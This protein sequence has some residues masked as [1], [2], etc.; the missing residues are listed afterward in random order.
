MSESQPGRQADTRDAAG[1]RVQTQKQEFAELE[2]NRASGDG[3]RVGRASDNHPT[4]DLMKA[5]NTG[6]FAEASPGQP[7]E[8]VAQDIGGPSGSEL[9][10]SAPFQSRVYYKSVARLGYQVAEALHYAHTN[11]VI[12]R[13]IKPSNLLI[14][15]EG[16]VWIT[17]FG[18]AKPLE[19]DGLTR[20]GD[21]LGTLR[22]M[23]PEQIEGK[24]D[25]RS[26]LYS[27]GLTLYELATLE[28][29]FA[30]DSHAQLFRSKQEGKIVPPRRLSP[31]LPRDLETII[32]KS[33]AADPQLR[34][35]NAGELAR[36]LQRFLEDRP[37]E[38]RRTS[39]WEKM[40]SW[41]RRNPAIA[42]LTGVALLLL[43]STALVASIGY[44]QTRAALGLAQKNAEALAAKSN[45]A[46]R[47]LEDAI[48]AQELAE[49]NESL[50]LLAEYRSLGN[51]ELALDAFEVIAANLAN[52]GVPQT[53]EWELAG[54]APV[55]AGQVTDEDARLLQS[56]LGFYQQF[57]VDEASD[58]VVVAKTA[59]AWT[60]MGAIHT[61]LGQYEQ[62]EQAYLDALQL[63]NSLLKELEETLAADSAGDRQRSTWLELVQDKSKAQDGLIRVYG[64]SNE[65]DKLL[66]AYGM[67]RDFLT[68]AV[69]QSSR[70]TERDPLRFALGRSLDQFCSTLIRMGLAESEFEDAQPESAP[71]SPRTLVR[72]FIRKLATPDAGLGA[73][74]APGGENFDGSFRPLRLRAELITSPLEFIL[75]ELQAAENIFAS[76]LND[77]PDNEA[78]RHA[79]A[80]TARHLMVL[81]QN[82]GSRRKAG[83]HFDSSV[84]LLESLVDEFP[85]NPT[86]RFE[87][88]DVYS[89]AQA[90]FPSVGSADAAREKIL[91]SIADAGT[92]ISR[93]PA[94]LEYRL[95][96]AQGHRQLAVLENSL[97]SLQLA[98]Y[99]LR[100][101]MD[102]L[103]ELRQEH[104]DP[105]G[106]LVSL[107]LNQKLYCDA[108]R[109]TG[110]ARD[111]AKLI[112][113][114][115]DVLDVVLE[116]LVQEARSR[117]S[118]FLA[119]VASS[120][121]LSKAKSHLEIGQWERALQFE[122]LSQY[123]SMR[124]FGGGRFGNSQ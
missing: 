59:R 121:L 93:F 66:L 100:T 5:T 58:R 110:I 57:H 54:D 112:Y 95:L 40:L 79:L 41:S 72:Q 88:A 109:T 91:Q 43:M 7:V 90:Q 86:Y 39:A 14:D 37:I 117:K 36:E 83:R 53:L 47:N 56:L 55:W 42:T 68:S 17:D 98:E 21:T 76:L 1:S 45:E 84:Q 44:F 61:R 35:A 9:Q 78:Y 64:Q 105:L 107:A 122:R 111:D 60:H 16:V 3:G 123:F 23:S 2:I 94:E 51:L 52:R 85:S 71:Q 87:L 26:D 31:G 65:L 62:A 96:E 6:S 124:P 70:A 20:T 80:H 15:G 67:Q 69:A 25:Q 104:P 33:T 106:P 10:Y 13:D 63:Q 24:A 30:S 97:G 108:L 34:F 118:P 89:M 12:H 102:K 81:E 77:A 4:F 11:R 32:L 46:E 74:N 29:A 28:R 119:R 99:E 114:S 115:L 116:P 73:A 101:A 49:E 103:V 22:Y 48:A 27:L 19:L 113:R 18:L 75:H 92:L 120:L 50:A 38:S 82:H 8:Q